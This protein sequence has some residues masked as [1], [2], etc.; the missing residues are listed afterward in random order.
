MAVIPS[1]YF[2]SQP[3]R[4]NRFNTYNQTTVEVK[5]T[6]SRATAKCQQKHIVTNM[7]LSCSSKS[8]CGPL[9]GYNTNPI[10]N[11][12]KIKTKSVLRNRDCAWKGDVRQDEIRF[13]WASL[14]TFISL[15]PS[16][17]VEPW[18]LQDEQTRSQQLQ[19]NI[20]LYEHLQHGAGWSSKHS[21]Q[22]QRVDVGVQMWP[23]V[24]V[25]VEE[26]AWMIQQSVGGGHTQHQSDTRGPHSWCEGSTL[27]LTFNEKSQGESKALDARWHQSG[28]G[29]G[30]ECHSS[31]A[32][33]HIHG[34]V[35]P[36]HQLDPGVVLPV[37][38]TGVRP[39]HHKLLNHR[40][41]SRDRSKVRMN[42]MRL[43]QVFS[44]C[45]DGAVG[46]TDPR[47]QQRSGSL[48][49][50]S[51]FFWRKVDGYVSL[52]AATS[53]SSD[54]EHASLSARSHRRGKKCQEWHGRQSWPLSGLQTE[55]MYFS[56]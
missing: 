23:A 36:V 20:V 48:P 18:A 53:S 47:M 42:E 26:K 54:G 43:D 41:C 52:W 24:H 55:G 45:A 56:D 25:V 5:A 13:T 15:R 21:H 9:R 35:L 37:V 28:G 32:E 40:A 44:L 22:Q 8:H 38:E 27:Q 29:G 30:D 19:N 10:W 1:I 2:S 4:D 50:S 14:I 34:A 33:E 39:I 7:M 3:R 17:L 46:K 12:K 51:P 11:A 31:D 49:Q 16:H 6:K